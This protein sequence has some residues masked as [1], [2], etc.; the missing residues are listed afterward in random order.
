MALSLHAEYLL[1]YLAGAKA[2]SPRDVVPFARIVND[3]T[4]QSRALV[5]A[6]ALGV[7][8]GRRNH[9]VRNASDLR[10]RVLALLAAEAGG[11]KASP[12]E[13]AP[14][15]GPFP[16]AQFPQALLPQTQESPSD[17]QMQIEAM[18]GESAK[19]G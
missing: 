9:P 16:Q 14:D 10:M 6:L 4:Q 15:S 18:L 19:V 3:G 12:V 7:T 5:K 1:G 13:G 2:L 8:D 17:P 11:A